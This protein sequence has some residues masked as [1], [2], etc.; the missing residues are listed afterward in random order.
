MLVSDKQEKSSVKQSVV[1]RY[2]ITNPPVN[3]PLSTDDLVFIICPSD[4]LFKQMQP[5]EEQNNAE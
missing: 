5:K 4:F 1:D 3:S 2:V